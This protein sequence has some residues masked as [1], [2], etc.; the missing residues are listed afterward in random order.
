MAVAG[1][2]SD[3]LDGLTRFV[4]FQPEGGRAL[5]GLGGATRTT[6][7]DR[8]RGHSAG[9]KSRWRIGSGQVG[10]AASRMG[11]GDDLL[12]R[13]VDLETDSST[14]AETD[15][16]DR[17]RR[18]SIQG[19]AREKGPAPG[20]KNLRSIGAALAL[21]L[22]LSLHVGYAFGHGPACAA[23]IW[24]SVLQGQR[25]LLRQFCLT[26]VYLGAAV[27]A[28]CGG[29]LGDK[30]GRRWSLVISALLPVAGWA[31]WSEARAP[32]QLTLGMLIS[33]RLL[34][35]VGSGMASVLVPVLI[36]E[37]APARMR[38][39][40]VCLHQLGIG[41]GFTVAY[42]VGWNTVDAA[43]AAEARDCIA[44]GWRLA[45]LMG[46][47]PTVLGL[48]V[49]LALPESPRWLIR[50]GA[51][52][53]GLAEASLRALRG[54]HQQQLVVAELAAL[55]KA[56]V[57]ST[58]PSYSWRQARLPTRIFLATAV[59][60]STQ[61]GGGFDSFVTPMETAKL[62]PG[63]QSLGLGHLS[64]RTLTVLVAAFA[65]AM[66]LLGALLCE[67]WFIGRPA[68]LAQLLVV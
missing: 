2:S 66:L 35:G 5:G 22:T 8:H 23:Q 57:V 46:I 67:Q 38:G 28:A 29:V 68:D 41:A 50:H 10:E 54:P 58:H 44:C 9:S 65:M 16:S 43:T 12:P 1:S 48:L 24:A 55:E 49:V 32:M 31:M 37:L 15:T 20:L 62:K 11:L 7:A 30:L 56:A 52:C 63:L 17:D 42:G 60:I 19:D 26:S 53:K 3:G 21:A 61:V 40:L 13:A 39:G 59:A 25:D 18:P 36:A 45:G 4:Q 64:P 47:V 33:G 27:G 6:S 14:A 34:V 51:A